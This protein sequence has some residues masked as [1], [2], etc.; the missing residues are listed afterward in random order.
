MFGVDGACLLRD[1]VI[2]IGLILIGM[3]LG[4]YLSESDI[5]GSRGVATELQQLI[6]LNR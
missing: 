6:Y 1:V 4:T 5:S 3:Y 2:E